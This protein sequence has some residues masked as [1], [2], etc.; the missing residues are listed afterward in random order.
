MS[1]ITKKSVS[2]LLAAL[3]LLTCL[4]LMSSAAETTRYDGKD[5]EIYTEGDYE[6][7]VV[8]SDAFIVKYNGT[9]ATISTPTSACGR[10]SQAITRA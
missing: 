6:F 7:I 3:M 5:Y 10:L 4:P 8:G 2:V 9:A 1:K